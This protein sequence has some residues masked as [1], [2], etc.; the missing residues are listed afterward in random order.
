V[1]E[2]L[3]SETTLGYFDPTKPTRLYVDGSKKDGVGSILAQLDGKTGK[4]QPIRYDSRALTD[5]E[6][7]Y[8]QIEVESLSIY[9]GI[10]KAHIYL[11]GLKEFVV[12]TDHEP[13]LSLYNKYKETIP[14]R[15]KHHKIMTQGYNYTLVYEKGSTN[16]SDYLSRHPR[17]DKD[18]CDEVD[19]Q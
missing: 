16:P 15:V 2:L 7:R 4:Y 13:L 19:E 9:T 6:T 10:M 12:V 3:Q 1:K 17:V 5:P 18:I 14:P 8:S 11:Y